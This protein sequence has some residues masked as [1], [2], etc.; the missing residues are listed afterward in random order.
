MFQEN[1]DV[2]IIKNDFKWLQKLEELREIRLGHVK[3]LNRY[4]INIGQA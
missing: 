1:L 2:F 3:F 4:Y